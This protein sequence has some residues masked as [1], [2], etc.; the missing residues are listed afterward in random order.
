MISLRYHYQTGLFSPFQI[1][2]RPNFRF[3]LYQTSPLLIG[4]LFPF[5]GSESTDEDALMDSLVSRI[6]AM[7]NFNVNRIIPIA[8]GDLDIYRDKISVYL[9]R[10]PR[11]GE[12]THLTSTQELVKIHNMCERYLDMKS[13]TFV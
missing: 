6:N 7:H 2:T 1:R 11:A 8:K 3:L 9:Q 5:Q 4:R 13:I 12:D 10:H